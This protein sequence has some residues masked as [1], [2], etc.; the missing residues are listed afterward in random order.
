MRLVFF[1][2]LRLLQDLT[3]IISALPRRVRSLALVSDAQGSVSLSLDCLNLS[4]F[5]GFCCCTHIAVA[6]SASTVF[7]WQSCLCVLLTLILP[8][9]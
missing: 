8:G 7:N 5:A 9:S 3:A 6:C 4:S 2:S 1:V